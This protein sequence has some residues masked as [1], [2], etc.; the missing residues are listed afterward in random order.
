MSIIKRAALASAMVSVLVMGVATTAYSKTSTTSGVFTAD[1]TTVTAG[2]IINLSI[3][4][5]N[6]QGKV[7]TQG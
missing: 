6:A 1:T 3:L 7:D 4:G 2:S 5:L